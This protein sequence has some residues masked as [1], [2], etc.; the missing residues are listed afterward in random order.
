MDEVA[1]RAVLV[2]EREATLLRIASM[3]EELAGLAA[4]VAN[5]NADDEHD[6]EGSTIAFEREQ[7]AALV[8]QARR[9]L[10]ELDHALARLAEGS[11]TVCAECG[12]P[13]AAER[14]AARPAARTCI[15][16]AGLR[17]GS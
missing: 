10:G 3:N 12:G 5:S 7:L 9:R 16:C 2:A 14:L 11:Y 17:R 8:E 4:A 13:I 1:V 15:R 6:P